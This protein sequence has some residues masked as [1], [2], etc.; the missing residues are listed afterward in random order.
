MLA[1]SEWRTLYNSGNLTGVQKQFFERRPA[2]QLFD[3]QNDPYE[4][5][6]L[7]SDPKYS[8]ILEDL[9]QLAFNEGQEYQRP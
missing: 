8:A 4:V 9:L 2:E 1:F 5:K 7:A 6:N 3:I